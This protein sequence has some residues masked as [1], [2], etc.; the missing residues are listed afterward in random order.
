MI[1][2]RE[3]MK[4]TLFISKAATMMAVVMAVTGLTACGAPKT[5]PSLQETESAPAQFRDSSES[6]F[7]LVTSEKLISTK[8]DSVWVNRG[9]LYKSLMF[10]SLLIA[11]PDLKGVKPDLAESYTVSDDSLTYTFKMKDHILWHDH[12][13]VTAEDVKWSVEAAL[14]GSLLNGIYSTAFSNVEGYHDFKNNKASG[15][16]GVT[17]D[18]DT[19]TF[20]LTRRSSTFLSIMAQFAVLPKHLLKDANLLELHN[21]P[22]WQKPVGNGMYQLKEFIPGNYGVYVPFEGYDGSKPSIGTIILSATGDV[23]AAAQKGDVDYLITSDPAQITQLDQMPHMTKYPID[24][25]YYRYLVCNIADE[26]GNVNEKLADPR[27]REALLMAI[28]RQSIFDSLFNGLGQV[29]DTGI[30]AFAP[31]YKSDKRYPYKPDE[32]KRLLYEAGFDFNQKIKLRF[33]ANDPASAS[34]MEAIAFSWETIGVKTDIAKFQ[35]SATEELFQIRDYDFALK[36]LSAFSYEEYYGEYT[37]SNANFSKI[38][39]KIPD[40]DKLVKELDMAVRPE[41]R[42]GVLEELQALEQKELYKLPLG[43]FGVCI[44]VNTDHVDTS[45]TQFGN[46]Y[47]YYDNNFSGWKLK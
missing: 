1:L 12:M 22:F 31:E 29:T 35:G 4:K 34:M 36:A 32:A 17:A 46:P 25:N 13:P 9:D 42:S 45:A 19:V 24:I 33:Y 5:S 21:D 41:E 10:R 39:G 2:E 43:T 23:T 11:T 8:L 37:S 26:N 3:L 18:G 30:P 15:L 16:S 7:R 6:V 14:S 20:R 40:F 28:D 38:F 47:F 27:I 44:Y